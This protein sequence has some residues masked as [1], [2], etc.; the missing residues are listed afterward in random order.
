MLWGGKEGSSRG[1]DMWDATLDAAEGSLFGQIVL[2][3]T[4][5]VFLLV[6]DVWLACLDCLTDIARCISG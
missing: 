2:L 1:H 6:V 3:P 4:N 5:D